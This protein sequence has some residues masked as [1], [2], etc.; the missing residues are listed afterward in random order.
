MK[1]IYRP[2]RETWS[3]LLARPTLDTKF[4]ERTVANILQDVKQHGD[5][6]LKHCARHFD[7]V[8]LDEFLVSPEEFDEA[9]RRVSNELKEA[10]GIAKANIEKFHR[11]QAERPEIIETTAG[12]SCWRKSVAIE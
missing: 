8:E 9:E 1:K 4:L 2:K 11:A 7:R 5:D 6:A 3:E 12:V 10:I